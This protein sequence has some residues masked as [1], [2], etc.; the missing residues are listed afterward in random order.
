[1]NK[2]LILV[3]TILIALLSFGQSEGD[4]TKQDPIELT[5]QLGNEENHLSFFPNNLELETGKLYKLIL[6]NPS[7]RKHYFS[8]EGLSRAVFTRKVQV[9][10]NEGQTIAEIK[11]PTREIEVYPKGTAEWWFVPIQTGEFTDLKCT[12]AGHAEAGMVGKILIK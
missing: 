11:G 9:L 5:V 3:M 1:M 2:L 6:V 8:S 10:G 4:L 12:I 7:E